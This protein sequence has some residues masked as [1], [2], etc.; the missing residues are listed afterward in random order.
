MTQYTEDQALDAICWSADVTDVETLVGHLRRMPRLRR[1][2]ID[3]LFVDTHGP[4][5]FALLRDDFPYLSV[6]FDAKYAEIPPKLAQLAKVGCGQQPWMLNCMANC[7]SNGQFEL[8]GKLKQEDLDGLKQFA[9]VCHDAGVAPCVVSVLTTKTDEMTA[10]EFSKRSRVE[11][12]LVYADLVLRAG[13]THMVCSPQ[14]LSALRAESH[15]NALQLVNAG[16]RPAGASKDDQ[17][18]ANTPRNTLDAGSNLLVIGRPLTNGDPAENLN[19]IVAEIL[20]A[21]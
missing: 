2:K 17:V 6:F 20:L 4:G 14:E 19:N 12:V 18:N 5:I 9:D 3:R 15:F 7:L 11:Q 13:F 1:I 21:T 8:T 16:I 10:A